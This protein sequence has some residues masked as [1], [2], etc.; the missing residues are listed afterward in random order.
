[1]MTFRNHDDYGVFCRSVYESS[2]ALQSLDDDLGTYDD[3]VHL[4][5]ARERLQEVYAHLAVATAVLDAAER[6]GYGAEPHAEH[7][8]V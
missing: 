6:S 8:E 2:K 3:T 7:P 4:G 5:Q 1:M